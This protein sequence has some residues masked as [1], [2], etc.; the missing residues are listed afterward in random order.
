MSPIIVSLSLLT[1]LHVLTYYAFVNTS[2]QETALEVNL[3]VGFCRFKSQDLF[4]FDKSN[5]YQGQVKCFICFGC[6]DFNL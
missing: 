4:F 3:L 1:I 2:I 6:N 5:L